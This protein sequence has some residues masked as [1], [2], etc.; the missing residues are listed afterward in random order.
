MILFKAKLI[1]VPRRHELIYTSTTYDYI[2]I[3]L[4]FG[5]C[6]L[7]VSLSELSTLI[8]PSVYNIISCTNYHFD[9]GIHN[10]TELWHQI[11][12]HTQQNKL[13]S[14]VH[15]HAYSFLLNKEM[16]CHVRLCFS[17]NSFLLIRAYHNPFNNFFNDFTRV[18]FEMFNLVNNVSI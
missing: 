11:G 2:L 14:H 9:I 4:L 12:Y 3:H 6:T 16:K 8:A 10:N 5:V 7:A 18:S 1:S 17:W 15:L 13:V